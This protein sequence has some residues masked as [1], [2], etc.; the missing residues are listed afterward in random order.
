MPMIR[1]G[2]LSSADRIAL[3]VCVRRQREDHVLPTGQM[4]SCCL[5][6]GKAVLGSQSFSTWTTTPSVGWH[7]TYLQDGWDAL[8]YD[9]WKGGQSSMM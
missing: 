8:A 2:F 3:E 5:M 7:K 6:M 4:R 9:G 1:P